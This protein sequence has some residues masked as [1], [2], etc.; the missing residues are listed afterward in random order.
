MAFARAIGDFNPVY[1]DAQIAA[2]SDV[3]GIIAPPTF[4]QASAHYDDD[5]PL[6]PRPGV[7]WFGSGTPTSGTSE[8]AGAESAEKPAPAD[9]GTGLHAEQHYVYHRPLL[10]GEMLTLHV[11]PGETWEKQGRRGGLLT[12]REVTTDYVDKDGDVVVQA[13]S[14]SVMTS[15]TVR[16]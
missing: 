5:Y 14:V 12:F 16:D 9:R 1:H 4:V 3:G 11:R 15:Q 13:R 6:R 10:A 2:S 8:A 7:R